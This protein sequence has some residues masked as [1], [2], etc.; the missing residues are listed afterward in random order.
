MEKV[1]ENTRL[2]FGGCGFGF[3]TGVEMMVK[4]QSV[5]EVQLGVF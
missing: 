1:L 3:R 5:L 4:T 2:A